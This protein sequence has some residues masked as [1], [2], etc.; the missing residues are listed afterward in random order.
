MCD[1]FRLIFGLVVDLF[2]SRAALEAEVLVL[3]QQIIVLRRGKPTRLV[4]M[5]VNAVEQ[6]NRHPDKA[7]GFPLIDPIL[8]QPG[9]C[10]VPQSVRCNSPSYAAQAVVDL[11]SAAET[12]II[13]FSHQLQFSSLDSVLLEVSIC[14][15]QRLAKGAEMSN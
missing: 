13:F 10:R 1:L 4:M 14:P 15:S 3:R 7:S 5:A 6:L 12:G 11:H 2:R 9:C 8:H